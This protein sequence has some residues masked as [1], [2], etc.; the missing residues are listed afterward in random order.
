MLVFYPET[1]WQ[2][3]PQL[4]FFA[5]KLVAHPET[6]ARIEL[7]L[8]ACQRLNLQIRTINTEVP[9]EILSKIH[10]PSYIRY[11]SSTCLGIPLGQ[12]ALTI[13]KHIDSYT[14]LNRFTYQAASHS[15]N[16][17]LLAAEAVLSGESTTY[18]LCRP[19]GHHAERA[20]AAGFCYFNNAALVA[21]TLSEQGKVAILDI[22]YHHGNGTQ[23]A[24]YDRADVLYVSLHADPVHEFPRSSGFRNERGT[25]AGLG[26]TN[27]YPLPKNI[28]SKQYLRVLREALEVVNSYAPNFVVLSLGFDTF[29]DDP[30]GGF[31]LAESIYGAI[32]DLVATELPYPTVIIQEG[33]YNLN[34]LGV[35]GQKFFTAYCQKH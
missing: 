21:E 10:S 12:E 3:A 22:D 24:F 4:Q 13:S 16:T 28:D 14:P 26:F 29:K 5:G 20:A 19:P 31:N 1:H 11:L 30:I 17:A 8:A 7:L 32:G 25:Q 33:G 35:L 6:P 2:H 18:A 34:K 23:H 27:N 15:A 9:A